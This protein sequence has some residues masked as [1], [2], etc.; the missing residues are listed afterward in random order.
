[1]KIIW[2]A[3]MEKYEKY[4]VLGGRQSVHIVFIFAA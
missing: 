2:F 1:M 3:N 4:M